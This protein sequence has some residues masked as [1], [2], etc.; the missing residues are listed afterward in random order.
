M[1]DEETP[2]ISSS[3]NDYQAQNQRRSIKKVII[4]NICALLS[5][6]I[7]ACYNM[8]VKTYK[9]DFL[10][11]LVFRASIQVILFGILGIIFKNRFWPEWTPE[12]QKKKYFLKCF[13][14][15]FQGICSALTLCF[16]FV[17][18]TKIPL[19]D[20]LT[21]IYSNPLFTMALAAIFMGERLRLFK[22][23]F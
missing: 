22:I 12:M 9:L 21:L 7:F 15:I 17:A 3:E 18:V 6:L 1:S 20:A 23:T 4:G 14:L 10:D 2:I 8:G 11:V 13:L 5:S 16:T 19:G